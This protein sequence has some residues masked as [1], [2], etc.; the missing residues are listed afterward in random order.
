[1]WQRLTEAVFV[2]EVM[3]R[4]IQCCL[5]FCCWLGKFSSFIHFLEHFLYS[6]DGILCN[7]RTAQAVKWLV[8]SSG[9]DRWRW[10]LLCVAA[11]IHS[12]NHFHT[13][14]YNQIQIYEAQ[15]K[16]SA[17][18]LTKWKICVMGHTNAL[19]TIVTLTACCFHV[20][21]NQ[22]MKIWDFERKLSVTGIHTCMHL[23]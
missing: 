3:I 12:T 6:R 7:L 11:L 19:W 5:S 21:N 13:N 10:P 15:I 17:S 14:R 16:T 2:V 9:D 8:L 22:G 20:W 1:M 23:L 4:R 18:I